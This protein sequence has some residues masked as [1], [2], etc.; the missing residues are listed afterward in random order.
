MA[1]LRSQ[2]LLKGN[3]VSSAD[4][5]I[6]ENRILQE[7]TLQLYG[8]VIDTH[9]HARARARVY[10]VNCINKHFKLYSGFADIFIW[11]FF[12]ELTSKV[13]RSFTL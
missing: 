4:T 6:H 11:I 5:Q 9:T 3:D 7:R 2:I 12:V 8:I 1:L 10:I 13:W